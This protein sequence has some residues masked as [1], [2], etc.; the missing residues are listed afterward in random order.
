MGKK[1]NTVNNG[2]LLPHNVKG[3]MMPGGGMMGPMGMMGMGMGVGRC[4]T[5]THI[6]SA[7]A[8]N[9]QQQQQ[10]QQ[11]QQPLSPKASG[12]TNG[13]NSNNNN[14]TTST[15]TTTTQPSSSGSNNNNNNVCSHLP[16]FA[17]QQQ[18]AHAKALMSTAPPPNPSFA[19]NKEEQLLV[20]REYEA[21]DPTVR[22]QYD[23]ICKR[24]ERACKGVHGA[25]CMVCVGDKIQSAV[26][27]DMR[28]MVG[29]GGADVLVLVMQRIIARTHTWGHYDLY[30]AFVWKYK[31]PLPYYECRGACDSPNVT[32]WIVVSWID[33]KKG[34][35]VFYDSDAEGKHLQWG[36]IFETIL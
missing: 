15:L 14:T 18:D 1:R 3:M 22:A 20:K 29:V 5:H 27:E 12:S 9:I 19:L 8:H 32:D 25:W 28:G 6:G 2:P 35:L 16:P 10:Q 11:Q 31:L 34:G 7:N 21:I 24:W 23:A 33:W 36:K 13:D 4:T 30:N 26:N 17:H